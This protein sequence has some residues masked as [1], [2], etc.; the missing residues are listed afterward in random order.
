LSLLSLNLSQYAV[1]SD[2]TPDQ[3]EC[4]IHGDMDLI[5]IANSLLTGRDARTE[6]EGKRDAQRTEAQ[7]AAHCLIVERSAGDSKLESQFHNSHTLHQQAAAF[8]RLHAYQRLTRER[9]PPLLTFFL[10]GNL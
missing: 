2:Q 1:V 9:P 6:P 4:Y 10:R 8:A 5:H 7:G 3:R